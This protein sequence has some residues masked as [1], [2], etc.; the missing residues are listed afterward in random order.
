MSIRRRRPFVSPLVA[1]GLALAACDYQEHEGASD[2]AADAGPDVWIQTG[3]L[4][5]DPASGMLVAGAPD[6]S[7]ADPELARLSDLVVLGAAGGGAVRVV[8]GPNGPLL[9]GPGDREPIVDRIADAPAGSAPAA[10]D[11]PRVAAGRWH[12]AH[13]RPVVVEGAAVDLAWAVAR[14]SPAPHGPAAGHA[15]AARL[16]VDE[17]R[18]PP[19]VLALRDATVRVFDAE[20]EVCIARVTGFE[21]QARLVH[22]PL[23]PWDPA[24]SDAE[25]FARGLRTLEAVVSPLAGAPDACARGVVAVG[26]G[27]PSPRTFAEIDTPRALA[28]RA[29][30][31]LCALPAWRAHTREVD[32]EGPDTNASWTERCRSLDRRATVRT[33]ESRDGQ[34]FTL[35]ADD[36][37][38]AGFVVDGKR[39]RGAGSFM[40]SHRP[41]AVIDLQADGVP[42]LVMPALDRAPRS[43]VGLAFAGDARRPTFASDWTPQAPVRA[44]AGGLGVP[45]FSVFEG[46]AER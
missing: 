34:R 23:G 1:A 17:A 15:F 40:L 31:A 18:L 25:I 22:E 13:G 32:L 21:L 12:V 44:L 19:E 2:D 26:V 29:V 11:D 20:R 6:Y 16:A 5:A 9:L 28:A 41:A 36:G 38:T 30:D 46:R 14:P 37:F 45:D 27:A 4:G 7:L 8:H 3:A 35:V 24:Y 42:E 39:L 10:D 33:F 43:V